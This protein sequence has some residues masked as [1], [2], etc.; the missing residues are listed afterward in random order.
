METECR[1][2][3]AEWAGIDIDQVTGFERSRGTAGWTSAALTQAASG[4]A[5]ARLASGFQPDR[6]ARSADARIL[7]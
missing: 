6:F 2:L 1:E 4:S 5:E 3:V 7:R